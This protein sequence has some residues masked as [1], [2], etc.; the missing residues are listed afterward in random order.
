MIHL[1]EWQLRMM[2]GEHW[3]LEN[4][5]P[6]IKLESLLCVCLCTFCVFWNSVTVTF[7]RNEL[8]NIR[9]LTWNMILLLHYLLY[10]CR[11]LYFICIL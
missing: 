5:M 10:I 3:R 2:T 9:Q 1:F 6:K 4:A 8:L 7:S 11:Y